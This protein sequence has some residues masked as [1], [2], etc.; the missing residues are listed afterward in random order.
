VNFSKSKNP[1]DCTGFPDSGGL[2]FI[3][4]AHLIIDQRKE[5]TEPHKEK[6]QPWHQ[7]DREIAQRYFHKHD[8]TGQGK[9]KDDDHDSDKK[10]NEFRHGFLQLMCRTIHL[11]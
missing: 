11:L 4:L 3:L 9:Q 2:C 5:G 1:P 7:K 10:S 6:E 8:L